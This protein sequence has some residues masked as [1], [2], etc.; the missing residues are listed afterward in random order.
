MF[1]NL[2][3]KLGGVFDR[4]RGKGALSEADVEAAMREIRISL[5]EAD[6]ALPVAR[7]FIEKTK[8]KLV[9][10]EL[11]KSVSPAQM[12][13]KLVQDSLT[14]M[15]GSEHQELD[16]AAEPPVAIMMV[17]LQGSGKTTSSAKLALRLKN[18]QNKKTL[19]A[20]LDVYRPAA[21]EQLKVLGEQ[22]EVDTLPIV[23]G[24]KP[25]AIAKRA[26]KEAKLG[27]YDLLIL[28]TA[29]RTHIDDELMKEVQAIEKI[30]SP[31]E[32]LLVA[33]SLT[34]QD[35]V[36]IAKE[37][38]EKLGLTGIVLTRLDGDG[39]G[40]AALSMKAVTGCPVK[41]IGVG[42]KVDEF[43]EFHPERIAGRILDK[44]DVVSLVEKAQETIDE[45]EA[46]KLEAKM[47]KGQFDL[48]DLAK[49]FDT[50]DKMGGM[51]SL[52]GMIPGLGKMKNEINEKM[53][54][55]ESQKQMNRM[56]AVLSSMTK[57]ERKNPKLFNGSRKVRVA[58]GAGVE[59]SDVN[60]IL[61]QHRQ[62]SDMMKKFSKKG[63]KGMMRQMSGLM[64]GKMP[65]GFPQ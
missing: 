65:P 12:V 47:K 38:N 26:M 49:Q 24:E 5:L 27:G 59:V 13:I 25:E 9:G 53:Q 63:K 29:G 50:M 48:D 64:G 45:D 39:R 36:N 33:D 11:I 55:P 7:E 15:L 51:G 28:D 58:K 2:S 10:E 56:R 44:G 41:F 14:E 21:Q 46:K 20:S 52:M 42:E 54:D 32:T 6:V 31:K 43:E 1:Q 61:K 18:K 22:V 57:A 37:F 60:K 19:L 34:G 23:E 17:G 3:D 8:S 30:A 35:A 40:G 62:M 4:L 16:L